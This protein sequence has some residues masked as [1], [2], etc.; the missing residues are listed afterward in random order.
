MFEELARTPF[1]E[2]SSGGHCIRIGDQGIARG[3]NRFDREAV[4]SY[5][6]AQRTGRTPS[7]ATVFG[8]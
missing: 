8:A 6:L 2:L 7:I 1:A 5:F 3:E 4:C